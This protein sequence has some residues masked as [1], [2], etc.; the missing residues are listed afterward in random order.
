MVTDLSHAASQ[1]ISEVADWLEQ[2]D[3]QDLLNDVTRFARRRPG[4]FLAIAAGAGLLAGRMGRGIRDAGSAD[5]SYATGRP[6][7]AAQTHLTYQEPLTS[8]TGQPVM[9][10]PG[11]DWHEETVDAR[12]PV[13]PVS[14]GQEF[15]GGDLR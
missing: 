6:A 1:R 12:G 8:T 7:G 3:P 2:R 9:T 11:R 14:G 10:E 15:R 5:N 4:T 13:D